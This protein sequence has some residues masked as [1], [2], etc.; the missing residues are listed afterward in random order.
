MRNDRRI[1]GP[2]AALVAALGVGT[3]AALGAA[4]RFAGEPLPVLG[5]V[6][7]FSLVDQAGRPVTGESLR[8]QVVVTSF[9]YTTCPDVC[10]TISARMASLGARVAADRRLASR[11]R[12]VSISVDPDHDTP[13]VLAEYAA[14]FG[15]DGER[16]RFLTGDAAGVRA[17]LLEGFKV[18]A[19]PVAAA[20][21]GH[22]GRHAVARTILHADTL[23]LSDRE[24]RVRGYYDGVSGDLDA[25]LADLRRLV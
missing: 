14:R 11:V 23:V 24:G 17:L 13:A 18:P 20:G 3:L 19:E 25:L 1:L 12:L 8:G 7:A 6:P 4:G 9:I 10:P 5:R 15:A 2:L 16:W 21:H 22:G